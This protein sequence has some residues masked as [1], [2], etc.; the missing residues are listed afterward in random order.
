MSGQGFLF[1]SSVWI[2]LAFTS[3]THHASAKAAIQRASASEPALFCRAT[4]QSVLR[5]LST[6][7]LAKAYGRVLTNRDALTLL[8][9]FLAS[10]SVAFVEEP[11]GLFARWRSLADLNTASPKR[12]MDAYLAAF[13]IEANLQMVAC[14]TDFKVFIGLNV[15]ILAPAPT[16]PA[17]GIP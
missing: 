14:D 2:A 8:D 3:H 12:W 4:Q 11:P 6:A 9:D 10:P 5:L 15:T 1:D 13:A 17:T 16:H 7:A